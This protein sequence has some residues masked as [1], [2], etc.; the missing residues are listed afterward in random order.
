[1]RKARSIEQGLG[2]SVRGEKDYCVIV[3]IGPELVKMIRS[4]ATRE[5]LSDQ[6]R[7]QIDIGLE[8]ASMAKGEIGGKEVPMDTLINLIN[9]CLKRDA[10]WKQFYVEQMDAVKETAPNAHVLDLFE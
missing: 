4:Q 9:Q 10:S 8:I 1:M 5:F 3:M 2:R 7:T 6:T